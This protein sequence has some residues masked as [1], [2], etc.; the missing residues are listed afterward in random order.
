MI[1]LHC[2][3]LPALD[4]GPADLQTSLQMARTALRE[5]IDTVVATP[6]V[7]LEFAT[8][9]QAI[10]DGAEELRAALAE[11]D[12]SLSVLTGAEI[13]LPRLVGLADDELR[14]LCLGSS[15]CALIESPYATAGPLIE[16]AL[17]DLRLRG[18]RPLLA[19]PERCPEF[20]RDIARLA[21]LVENG[22]FCSLTAGSVAGRFGSTVKRF[23]RRLL[24][25]NLV[26]NLSSDA[27]DPVR[28]A[29]A[30]RFAFD[31]RD[32]PIATADVQGWL[33]SSVPSAILADAPL[34]ARPRGR[35]PSRWRRLAGG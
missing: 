5:G 21:R 10:R 27:H 18:F 6:H 8:E 15:S 3:L 34:P 32:G 23:A 20:Q 24:Q 33:T 7:N 2:H 26:H 4:D 22:M 14:A 16:D 35:S 9:A 13:A 28:R 25:E 11:E 29:P 1:D 17:F 30:L 12:L 19:H 31:E